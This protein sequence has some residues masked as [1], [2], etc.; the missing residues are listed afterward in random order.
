M[1]RV[2]CKGCGKKRARED[3]GY[4]SRCLE[5]RAE[6]ERQR[7]LNLAECV[8]CGRHRDEV[9]VLY[10]GYCQWCHAPR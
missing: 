10:G 3:E 7:I 2:R 8:G 1:S 5:E 6:R 9:G 4:C